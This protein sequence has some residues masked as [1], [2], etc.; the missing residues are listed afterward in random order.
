MA[1]YQGPHSYQG[2]HLPVRLVNQ[3]VLYTMV[4]SVIDAIK[5]LWVFAISV[6]TVLVCQVLNW[7]VSP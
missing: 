5:P 6:W 3:L 4:F 2:L 7:D 1:A